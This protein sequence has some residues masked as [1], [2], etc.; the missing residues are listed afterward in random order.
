MK[1]LN[2]Y[3]N[4]GSRE[5]DAI[6]FALWCIVNNIDAMNCPSEE[7]RKYK[8]IFDK[9]HYTQNGWHPT[10]VENET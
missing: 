8:R 7:Y 9:D 6:Q 1:E 3:T 4:K 2:I 10:E 5:Q